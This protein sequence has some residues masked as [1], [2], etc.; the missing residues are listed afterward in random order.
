VELSAAEQDML[1]GKEGE[2]V[3]RALA[4]Q[5]EVGRFSA[6]AASCPSPTPI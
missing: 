5:M 1:A 2:A 6:P 3:R 4:Y